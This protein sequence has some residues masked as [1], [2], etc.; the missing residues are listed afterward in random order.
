MTALELSAA[1]RAGKIGVPEAASS[2]IDRIEQSNNKYNAFITIAKENALR[3]AQE[4]QARI[5]NK[6]ELSPLAGVPVALKD[7]ISTAGLETT[8]ASKMLKDY[9]PIYNA[10]VTEKLERAGMIMIG[11]LNMDEFALEQSVSLNAA[12]NPWDENCPAGDGSAAAVAAGMTPIAVGSDTG[13]SIRRPCSYC[14][15]TGIKP[16]YGSVSRFGI[17]ACASS[18]DQGGAIGQDIDDCAALLQLVSG[19]DERDSTCIIKEAF[20]FK[21][22]GKSQGIKIGFYFSGGID[23]DVKKAVLAA[24]KELEDAGALVEEFEMP[25]TD[26][27]IPAYSIIRAAEVSSNLAKYDGLKYGHRSADAKTLSEVYRFSRSEGFGFDVKRNIMLGSLVLSSDYY[28]TYYR[29]ALQVRSLIKD[30][31]N[32]LFTKY[33]LILSPVTPYM[34][35]ANSDDP[36]QIYMDSIYTA[37]SDL[38]GLPA[39][40]LPCGFNNQG[41]PLGFQLIGN[42]FSEK[43]IVDAGRV[44]QKRTEHHRRRPGGVQ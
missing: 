12:R 3:R 4:V 38:A 14:G 32:K 7:N 2:Y 25:L 10:A 39:A 30:A 23:D 33:D 42:A 17:A 16:T 13:G 1:I 43:I 31:Y 19:P 26:Y 20:D 34:S 24:A 27:V 18:L 5:D 44:Y 21:E 6:E 41:M 35:G 40:A 36:M 9:K 15:V 29:K 22:Q 28:D 11:K 37:S 8:C